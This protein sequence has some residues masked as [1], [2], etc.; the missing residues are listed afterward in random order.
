MLS[1]KNINTLLY[2]P[3][4]FYDYIN[5]ILKILI[6]GLSMT[7]IEFVIGVICLKFLKIR[8]W[9][10]SKQKGNIMGVICPLYSFIWLVIGSLYYFL[11]NPFI[12]DAIAFIS[13][14]LIYTYFIGIVIGMIVVDFA[15]S[16]HLATRLRQFKKYEI[17]KFDEYKHNFLQ[18]LRKYR[19]HK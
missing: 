14:N 15:Y 3:V 11:I 16:F 5:I 9:D 17:I 19:N 7:L 6:I 10:Y 12:I 4:P 2:W 8:L 18:R 13:D 1:S